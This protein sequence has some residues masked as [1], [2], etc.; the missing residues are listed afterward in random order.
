MSA[1]C[2]PFERGAEDA[3]ADATSSPTAARSATPRATRTATGVALAA[4][5]TNAPIATREPTPYSPPGVYEVSATPSSPPVQS[6]TAEP[7]SSSPPV[8]SGTPDPALGRPPYF[9]TEELTAADLAARGAGV[10]GRGALNIA[11]IV[12]TAIG[13]DAPVVAG[14][15][16][17]NG[18]MPTPPDKDTVLWNDFS[19]WPGFGGLPGAGGN[20][21]L[22]GDGYRPAGIGVFGNL[23]RLE[24]GSIVRLTLTNGQAAC[25]RIRWNKYASPPVVSFE[26]LVS[27]TSPESVS[28][29]SAGRGGAERRIAW[30]PVT[31]C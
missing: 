23:G 12:I 11:R 9:G 7:T 3:S 13:V 1:G 30:G 19:L 22:S 24:P 31:A 18:M 20:V 27:A 2:G 4:T 15:V 25:Y 26:E 5:A 8:A 17:P 10:P 29:I 6:P 21:V 16:P 14:A 28:L